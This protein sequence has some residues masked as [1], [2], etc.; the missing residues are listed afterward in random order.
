MAELTLTPS[1]VSDD[2]F[3]R[4]DSSAF[5]TTGAF[6]TGNYNGLGAINGFI[7]FDDALAEL[8]AGATITSA[9]L[10]LKAYTTQTGT[11]CRLIIRAVDADNPA[12]PTTYSGAENATRTTASVSWEPPAMSVD[13]VHNSPDISSIIQEIVDRPGW[14][15]GQHI[16]IYIEDNGSTSSARRQ[17]HSVDTGTAPILTINYSTTAQ[18]TQSA[19]GVLITGGA[20]SA[21]IQFTSG[22]AG[23]LTLDGLSDAKPNPLKTLYRINCGGQSWGAWEADTPYYVNVGD[24][25]S[26]TA[27]Q[28]LSAVPGVLEQ[29]LQVHRWTNTGTDLIYQFDVTGYSTVEVTLYFSE[30]YTTFT[31]PGDRVIDIYVDGVLRADNYD[32]FVAAG[33]AQNKGTALHYI[34]SPSSSTLEIRAVR[35][36]HAPMISGILVE[37]P[38]TQNNAGDTTPAGSLGRG[39]FTNRSG[40][41]TLSGVLSTAVS[42]IRSTAG[43][44]SPSGW[45]GTLQSRT[46]LENGELIPTGLLYRALNAL[47][48]LSGSET[49]SGTLLSYLRAL[50]SAAGTLTSAGVL[51][52]LLSYLRSVSGSVSLVGSVLTVHN[53]V[54]STPQIGDGDLL[55]S[56]LLEA[57]IWPA[58]AMGSVQ[59][60][61][62][63]LRGTD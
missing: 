55:S 36:N 8:P 28:D 50:R 52:R 57:L 39:V 33:N 20:L 46:Q 7:R 48:V 44:L 9:Y 12:A 23:S 43:A 45:L 42:F 61:V 24:I 58:P 53:T 31:N 38:D 41:V 4:E 51:S 16:L 56:G 21:A 2:G 15:A 5:G 18:H 37:A 60:V 1:A 17:W 19:A 34:I 54:P 14:A 26:T 49:S 25:Y 63:P 40:S 10:T 3:W 62:G 6:S 11:V 29:V 32:P 13:T 22:V 47:R 30:I 59:Y 35:V 27:P